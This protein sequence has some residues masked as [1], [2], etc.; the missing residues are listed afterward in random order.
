[1]KRRE[2]ISVVGGAAAWPRLAHAQKA[3]I[4]I[5]FLAAGAAGSANSTVQIGAIKQGL[6]DNGLIDGQDFALESRFAAGDY[7]RFPGLAR[8]L[9]QAGARVILVNTIASVRAAQNVTWMPYSRRLPR[10][11]PTRF[12]S[13]RIQEL[14]IW[15]IASRRWRSDCQV[16]RPRRI[17]PNLAA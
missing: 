15:P 5:G 9:A 8:E 4:S 13:W 7:E 1:M 14:S 6:R 17:T 12:I 2:F 3:P 10:G 11:I 16:L